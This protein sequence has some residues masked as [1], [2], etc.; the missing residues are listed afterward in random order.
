MELTVNRFEVS[1]NGLA[2]IGHLSVWG[3]FESFSLENK[4]LAISVGTF[5]VVIDQS[6]LFTEKETAAAGRPV[7]G[8]SPHILNVPGRQ[9]I[10][11][12]SG[13]TDTAVVGCIAVGLVHPDH[14]DFIGSSMLA[15]RALVPKIEAALGLKRVAGGPETRVHGEFPPGSQ[16][17]LWHYEKTGTPDP[18]GV[19]ITVSDDLADPS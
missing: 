13:N 7:L 5:K 15:V 1:A 17:D 10:R 3:I 14:Q 12:H 6:P 8:F 2:F 16:S 11:I 9:G 18:D 19:T 4:A